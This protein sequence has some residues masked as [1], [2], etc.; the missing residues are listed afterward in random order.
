MLGLAPED[1][2]GPNVGAGGQPAETLGTGGEMKVFP[3]AAVLLVC[4]ARIQG[5]DLVCVSR[6]QECRV[7]LC[8]VAESVL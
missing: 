5:S 1:L 4:G 3:C 6:F 7:A 2:K 8:G